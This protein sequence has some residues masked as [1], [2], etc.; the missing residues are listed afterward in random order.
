VCMKYLSAVGC[1]SKS[2]DRCA[3]PNHAHFIPNV[4]SPIVYKHIDENM[5]GVRAELRK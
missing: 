3:F 5:G 2:D 1:S 4:L